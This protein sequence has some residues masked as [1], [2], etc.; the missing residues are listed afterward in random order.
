M[1]W[2]DIATG[3]R[4][5]PPKQK[6]ESDRPV[7][8]FVE[9]HYD[10][11]CAALERGYSFDEISEHL[12]S[13]QVQIRPSTLRGYVREIRTKRLKQERKAKRDRLKEESAPYR[14]QQVQE[15]V[16][17]LEA[18]NS[19]SPAIVREPTT[20]SSSVGD[21]AISPLQDSAERSPKVVQ[22]I[23]KNKRPSVESKPEGNN[24]DYYNSDA[25]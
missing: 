25:L 6:S 20:L 9:E 10:D 8:E 22:M 19:S 12:Q 14:R 11:I 24:L 21:R 16:V 15:G 4:S 13:G 17:E 18:T 7:F 2:K 3:L 1:S 23:E 5:L